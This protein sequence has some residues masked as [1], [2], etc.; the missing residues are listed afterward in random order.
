[1]ESL[2]ILGGWLIGTAA[3][4]WAAEYVVTRLPEEGADQWGNQ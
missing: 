2:M 3:L 1:M 4:L